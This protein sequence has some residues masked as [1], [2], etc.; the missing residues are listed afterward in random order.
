MS[1]ELRR[2]S[3]PGVGRAKF[4]CLSLLDQGETKTTGSGLDQTSLRIAT[5]VAERIRNAL[6]ELPDPASVC[7]RPLHTSVWLNGQRKSL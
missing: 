5:K 6:I 1:D 7:G 4:Q 2:G 3:I